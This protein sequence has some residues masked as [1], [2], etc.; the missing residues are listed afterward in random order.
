MG[1][2]HSS[3]LCIGGDSFV[4]SDLGRTCGASDHLAGVS[5][6]DVPGEP[7]L[8]LDKGRVELTRLNTP[9]DRNI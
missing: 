5:F 6:R 8:P 3:S 2:G 1:P 4:V 9:W 7:P